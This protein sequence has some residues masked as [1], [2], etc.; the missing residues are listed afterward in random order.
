MALSKKGY[1][2]CGSQLLYKLE[3]V[4]LILGRKATT[5]TTRATK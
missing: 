4:E 3:T 1:G 5:Q 2:L